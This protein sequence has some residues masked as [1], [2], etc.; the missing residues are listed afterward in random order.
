[1]TGRAVILG[2]GIGGLT[3][4]NYLFRAGWS[5]EVLERSPN[6]P[7]TGTALGMWPQAMD[8][9][10]AIGVGDRVRTLGAPQRGGGLLRPDGAV[11]G[12]VES[13]QTLYLLSR[14]AL[15]EALTDGLPAGAISFGSPAPAVDE[16]SDYD[17]VIGAEGLRSPT[18]RQL[19]G[20]RYDPVYTGATAWRGW[21]PGN[22]H[23]VSETWDANALFG[24]TPRDGGLVN[25]F[26]SIR[27]DAGTRGGVEFL[28]SRFGHWHDDVR[29]V[30]DGITPD[31][32]LHHDLY[33]S[34]PLPS[35]VSK[36]VALI[37]D[38]AHAM[39]PNLGRG[40]CEA[41]VDGVTLGRLLTEHGT[42]SGGV[43]LALKKY[44]RTR[45]RPTRMLVRGS[46]VMMSVAMTTRM[47][48]LRDLAVGIGSKLA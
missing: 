3:A 1:M 32:M 45:R 27:A 25:W 44:D 13:K 2:G 18:R 19:F 47:R 9:L 30:L 4:A 6:L 41:L 23:T 22:R 38:A 34:P 46:K 40:A 26:A 12:A 11:I 39:A 17:V 5:V 16:L 48:P 7:A 36:N 20:D 35:Y 28:R 24:I 31:A 8:A 15:L 29:T 33:E 14:P 42:R 37:G 10:D 21:V 43:E